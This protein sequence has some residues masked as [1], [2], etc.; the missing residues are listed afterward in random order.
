MIKIGDRCVHNGRPAQ[1]VYIHPNGDVELLYPDHGVIYS[2]EGRKWEDITDQYHLA[3]DFVTDEAKE[4]YHHVFIASKVPVDQLAPFILPSNM[5]EGQAL[6]WVPDDIPDEEKL[7]WVHEWRGQM[8]RDHYD[9]AY[10]LRVQWHQ[11]LSK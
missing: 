10:L 8:I 7:K 1:V 2:S 11:A 9:R 4:Y 3:M 5:S 6:T